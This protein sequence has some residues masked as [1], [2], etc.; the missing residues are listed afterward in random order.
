LKIGTGIEFSKAPHP[1][2]D[3]D[4][5]PDIEKANPLLGHFNGER[6]TGNGER[7]F[8]GSIFR[9][10]IRYARRIENGNLE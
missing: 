9:V 1:D 6:K 2:I 7:K 4:T 3:Y 5:D 10:I 8:C